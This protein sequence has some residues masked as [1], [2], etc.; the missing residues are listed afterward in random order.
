VD[1]NRRDLYAHE[2]YREVHSKC[3]DAT[4]CREIRDAWPAQVRNKD[5]KRYITKELRNEK[6]LHN[7]LICH[8][9]KR[10]QFVLKFEN[11]QRVAGRAITIL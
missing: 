7:G 1:E 9:S 8:A 11:Y 3:S 2:V 4:T 6:G 5:L 10:I